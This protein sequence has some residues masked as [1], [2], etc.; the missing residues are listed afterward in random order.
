M[1]LFGKKKKESKMVGQ[2]TA[3]AQNETT[4]FG[5]NLQ[6]KGRV[7]GNGNIIILGSLDGE[8]RLKGRLKIA[9]PAKIKGE[10]NADVI[11]VNGNVHGSLTANGR[12]HLDQTARIK[13]RIQTPKLSITEGAIFDGEIHM[14]AQATKPDK[15]IGADAGVSSQTT[16][17]SAQ[18]STPG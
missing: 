16:P 17:P 10:V 13:G 18:K 8:F 14:G 9:Q 15:S 3:L 12:V 6:I 4:Y 5:K 1:Q 7:S 2:S 11:S